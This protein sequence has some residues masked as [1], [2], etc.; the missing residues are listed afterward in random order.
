MFAAIYSQIECAV[1]LL[2]SD[3]DANAVDDFGR[4]ALYYAK[5][6]GNKAFLRL[7]KDKGPTTALPG[8][9]SDKKTWYE[10]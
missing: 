5:V 9:N 2:Q 8:T 1:L 3:A 6:E 10:E 7:L 4:T